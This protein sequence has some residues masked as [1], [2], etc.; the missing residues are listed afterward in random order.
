MN[1][2]ESSDNGTINENMVC[3]I[4]CNFFSGELWIPI[5]FREQSLT[6]QG[7][8]HLGIMEQFPSALFERL[9]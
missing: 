8:E 9:Y 1:V 7:N 4:R 5:I 2:P 6:K 3:S